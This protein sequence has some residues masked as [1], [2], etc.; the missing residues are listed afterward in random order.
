M[1]LGKFFSAIA[2]QFN[3]LGNWLFERDPI[4]QMQLEYDKSVEQLKEGRVG[5]EQ[6][7]GLVE[8]VT[9]QVKEGEAQITKLTAQAKAYLK[10]G[11]RETAANFALQLTKAKAQLEENRQQLAMHEEAYNNNLLKIQFANKKLG[12][13]K[14]KIQKYDADLKMSEAEA[15]IAKVTSTLNMDLTTDFG[16]IEDVI[17]RRIDA[18]RGKARVAADMS[19]QGLDKIKAEE[20]LEKSMADDALRDLEVELGMRSPETTPVAQAQKDLGPAEKEAAK[21]ELEKLEKA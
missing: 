6:Y 7:R 1:I 16:K 15:E 18:N 20:T 21:K 4:A 11:N 2:A 9:R 3:K 5:L 10:M 17:Q 12:E 14:D 8:R 13:L 19:Q